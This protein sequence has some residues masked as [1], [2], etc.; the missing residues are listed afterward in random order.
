MGGEPAPTRK[1]LD[2]LSKRVQKEGRPYR[3]LR[4]I[5]PE[6]N[7]LFAAVMRGEHLLDGFRNRDL[8]EAIAPGVRPRSARGRSVAGRGTR[9]VRLLRAHGLIRKVPRT[10]L[11]RITPKGHHAMTTALKLRELD[12]PGI[13]A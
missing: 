7:D 11:D 8:R 9:Y 6:D 10:Q 5:A 12:V 3:A 2:P 4:P 1:V 13:A